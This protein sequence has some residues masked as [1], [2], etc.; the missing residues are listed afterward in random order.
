M[1]A[2]SVEAG[3]AMCLVTGLKTV[4]CRSWDTNYRG[5]IIICSTAKKLHGT[6][7]FLGTCISSISRYV[8]NYFPFFLL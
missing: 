2:L 1:K 3:Y 6:I 5:D 4:E 8:I 7:P